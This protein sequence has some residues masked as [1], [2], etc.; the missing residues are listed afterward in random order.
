MFNFFFLGTID[1]MPYTETSSDTLAMFSFGTVPLL[2]SGV[3]L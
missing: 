3:G 2:K 1:A